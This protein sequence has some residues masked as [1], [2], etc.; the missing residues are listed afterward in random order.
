MFTT[1]SHAPPPT[2]QQVLWKCSHEVLHRPKEENGLPCIPVA[3]LYYVQIVSHPQ[4]TQRDFM[5]YLLPEKMINRY[6][7]LLCY[8]FSINI[9]MRTY[10]TCVWVPW[11]LRESVCPL[12]VEL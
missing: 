8:D 1:S 10:A 5:L 3:I 2:Q 12:E 6:L 9:Y 11:N 4:L 7:R